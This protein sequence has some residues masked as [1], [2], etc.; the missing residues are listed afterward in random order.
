MDA[1]LVVVGVAGPIAITVGSAFAV[2]GI[3]LRAALSAGRRTDG[4]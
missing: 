2:T 3:V 4:G 1:F